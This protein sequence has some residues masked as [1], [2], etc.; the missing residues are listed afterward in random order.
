MHD[1]LKSR[2]A[3]FRSENN[4]RD[5][6]NLLSVNDKKHE[7]NGPLHVEMFSDRWSGSVTGVVVSGRRRG[8]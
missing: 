1:S 3:Y 7:R 4:L 8:Q 2:L 5:F 6:L